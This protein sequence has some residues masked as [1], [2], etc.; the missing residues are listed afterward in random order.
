M[1]AGVIPAILYFTS[2][3]LMVDY[4]AIKLK[5]IGFPRQALPN[6]LSI[7]KKGYLFIPVFLLFY[8]LLTGWTVIF[9]GFAALI[10][11][12]AVSWLNAAINRKTELG[13][14]LM[15][16]IKALENGAR[17]SI[18]IMAVCAAAGIIMGVIALTG[19]GIKFA[20]LLLRIA[21]ANELLALIFAMGVAI[22]LGMGMPT[23]AAYAI[24]ASILAPGLVRMGLPVIVAHLFVFYYACLS[25][26]TPPVA[27]AA[28]AASGISGSD[29]MK[30]SYM[31]FR[32]GLT[33]YVVPFMFYYSPALIF[34]NQKDAMLLQTLLADGTETVTALAVITILLRTA[35]ALV[36]VWSLASAVQGWYFG[37]ASIWVQGA[38]FV[39][40]LTLVV[41]HIGVNL[42]GLAMLAVLAFVQL[43]ACS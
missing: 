13:M 9:A 24:A 3:Y 10:S 7:M 23:T 6:F 28:Y 29:P 11:S 21:G 43:R 12:F 41:A 1:L 17:G 5:L 16:V 35:I 39:I 2:V 33:A 22:L 37:K 34:G 25:A 18:Q 36:G 38:L 26:I 31:S 32:L 30:T 15:K 42:A 4:E 20:D 27:L 14:G 19:V 8:L 40:T